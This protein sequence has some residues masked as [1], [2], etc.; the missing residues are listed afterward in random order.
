MASSTDSNEKKIKMLYGVIGALAVLLI[1]M[2]VLLSRQKTEYVELVGEHTSLTVERND[3]EA[4][5][6]EMLTQYDALTV[7][8]EELSA[9]IIQQKEEIASL[10]E[11]VSKLDKDDKNLRWEISKLKKEAGTLRS[12]MKG[13]LYTIDSL[14]QQNKQLTNENVTLSSNLSTVTTQKN[15]LQTTVADQEGLIK[16]GSVIPAMNMT[17]NGLRV[18]SSGK[19]EETNRASR[20][21]MVRACCT[22]GEN[23]ISK[24]GAKVLYMRIIS[25]EGVVLED[26]NSPNA[27]FNYEGVT[28]K[29]SARRDFQ[30]ENKPQDLCV[31]YTVGEELSTGQYIVE[32]YESG[33]LIG[34][35]SFDLR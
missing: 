14:N 13:Y 19:Q 15:Q 18:K 17:A 1:I 5:L 11:K 29:Y 31:F 9:E 3:L 4:E 8:N 32:L 12:I 26:S 2:A 35:T 16:T 20:S 34:K 33:A 30:Y 21:E 24:P 10:M 28:G 7:D 6:Q 25:P 23:R 27:T 22:L